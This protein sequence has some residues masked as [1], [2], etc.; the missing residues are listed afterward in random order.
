MTASTGKTQI[1]NTLARRTAAAAVLAASVGVGWVLYGMS[2]HVSKEPASNQCAAS[3]EIAE[4]VSTFA[5]GE[6]AAVS[7]AKTPRPLAALEFENGPG[8]R[9]KSSEFRGRAILLNLWATWC[10]PCREEMP[11]LDKLQD[12]L[13]GPDFEVVAISIDTARLEKRQSFL[14]EA[15]VEHLGFYADPTAEVFQV[16]KKS[17]KVVGLP[18]TLLIDASGCEI[19]SMAGPADW[20]SEDA[21]MLISA[22]KK[23]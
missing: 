23:R 13:G 14:K 17:G 16:L 11:A 18:T 4:R 21:A 1:L 12:R 10:I 2:A 6:V 20:A 7:I 5:R 19:G 8:S 9:R 15:G 22:L 3:K